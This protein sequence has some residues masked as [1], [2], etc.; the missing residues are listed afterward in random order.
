MDL[1]ALL[2]PTLLGPLRGDGTA[3]SPPSLRCSLRLCTTCSSFSDFTPPLKQFCLLKNWSLQL[4]GLPSHSCTTHSVTAQ[5]ACTTQPLAQHNH[6]HWRTCTLDLTLSRDRDASGTFNHRLV[7]QRQ[8]SL[9]SEDEE[10]TTGSEVTED[11]V[12]DEEEQS[13]KQGEAGWRYGEVA[14]GLTKFFSLFLR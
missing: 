9:L 6:Q 8:Q 14:D 7:F 5:P 13:K 1:E 2:E 4:V 3:V 10:Y 11:E 12:G